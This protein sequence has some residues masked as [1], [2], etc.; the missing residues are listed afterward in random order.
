VIDQRH[1][2][3]RFEGGLDEVVS[4]AI[5]PERDEAGARPQHP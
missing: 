5:P 2:R 1:V 3:A 4:V